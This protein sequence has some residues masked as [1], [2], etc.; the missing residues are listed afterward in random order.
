MV[1]LASHE[2]VQQRTVEHVPQIFKE[3][4]VTTRLASHEQVQQRTV[5]HVLQIFKETVETMRLASHEQVQQRTEVGSFLPLEEFA[6]PVNNQVHQEQIDRIAHLELASKRAAESCAALAFFCVGVPSWRCRLRHF[7]FAESPAKSSDSA[8][9]SMSTRSASCTRT[10]TA[11]IGQLDLGSPPIASAKM[12]SG[13]AIVMQA[14]D[15]ET[16]R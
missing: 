13:R 1:G 5:E 9:G 12:A 3:N 10:R 16:E 15:S 14:A 2:R 11:G 4:A 7:R 6:A 8:M